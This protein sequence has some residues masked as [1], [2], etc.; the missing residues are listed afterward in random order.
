MEGDSGQQRLS[1]NPKCVIFLGAKPPLGLTSVTTHMLTPKRF[2]MQYL[3]YFFSLLFDIIYK[4]S[5]G[6][7]E[8]FWRMTGGCLEGFWKGSVRCL[9]SMKVRAFMASFDHL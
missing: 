1:Q 2:N 6:C 7:L 3:E 4:V 9:E 8:D 5:G